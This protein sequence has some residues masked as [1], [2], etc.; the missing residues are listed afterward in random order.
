MFNVKNLDIPPAVATLYARCKEAIPVQVKDSAQRIAT[1]VAPHFRLVVGMA[2]A[3]VLGL[4]IARRYWG[5]KSCGKE[6]A[7]LPSPQ[8]G[9]HQ[10]LKKVEEMAWRTSSTVAGGKYPKE[11]FEKELCGLKRTYERTFDD[12]ATP[13]LVG[14]DCKE[15]KD[16]W[17][18]ARALHQVFEALNACCVKSGGAAVEAL[19]LAEPQKVITA[20]QEQKPA[21][22]IRK[23]MRSVVT[24]LFFEFAAVDTN[25]EQLLKGREWKGMPPTPPQWR[26]FVECPAKLCYEA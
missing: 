11:V 26:Q 21:H 7:P 6:E 12:I 18:K 22:E 15:L 23:S 4:L 2:G 20:L 1:C 14:K 24:R 10:E 3:I 16:E 17:A 9:L 13:L 25:V 8:E 19:F 5:A